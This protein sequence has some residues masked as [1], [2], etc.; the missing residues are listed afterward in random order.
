MRVSLQDG[1]KHV[2]NRINPFLVR[3]SKRLGVSMAPLL[4]QNN[5]EDQFRQKISLFLVKDV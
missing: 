2:S 1:G 3:P 5:S 4:Q